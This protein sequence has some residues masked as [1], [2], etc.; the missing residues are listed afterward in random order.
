[1]F[2]CEHVAGELGL[3]GG[4]ASFV[5]RIEE[6]W[7]IEKNSGKC[8]TVLYCRQRSGQRSGRTF[9]TPYNAAT[10][11]SLFCFGMHLCDSHKDL[12]NVNAVRE[13]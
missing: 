13:I 3:F 12:L 7:G 11:K 9:I 4:D 1:M 2:S 8:L 6:E 10:N 5:R